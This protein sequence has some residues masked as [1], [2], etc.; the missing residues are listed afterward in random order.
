MPEPDQAA[1]A[2]REPEDIPP[3]PEPVD[4]EPPDEAG[5]EQPEPPPEPTQPVAP[6]AY[7]REDEERDMATQAENEEGSVDRRDATEVA[8]ELLAQ[9][10]DAKPL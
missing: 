10:L 9:E 7:T 4:D 5:D 2:R 6:A 8:M 3:P 1:R